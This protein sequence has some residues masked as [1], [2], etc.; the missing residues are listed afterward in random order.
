MAGPT[1]PAIPIS[2]MNFFE[3]QEHARKSS[4]KLVIWF[5][6]CVLGVV[7]LVYTVLAFSAIAGASGS[8]V[9]QNAY[10]PPSFWQPELFLA[11]FVIVG[12]IILIGSLFKLARLSGGGAV[13]ARD[14]GGRPVDPDTRNPLE[15]RLLN[16]V[17]EMAIASGTP[18]PEVWVMDHEDGINAFAAGTDPGNAV[19]GVT[20]GTLEQLT[21]S[22]LQ[23]VIGH[24]YSHILNGDMKLNMRLTG[25][26]FG[27]VM[28]ALVGR[29]LIRSVRFMRGSRNGKGNAVIVG[30]VLLGL[31]VWIIGSIGVLFA[32]MLQA[33][34]SRQREFLADASAVQF[35]RYPDGIAGALKKISSFPDHGK[36]VAAK[37]TEARHMFFASS[38]LSSVLATHPPLEERIRAIEPNWDGKYPECGTDAV[39]DS[40]FKSVG[41]RPTPPPLPVGM[42]SPI[43]IPG[44][45]GALTGMVAAAAM[46]EQEQPQGNSLAQAQAMLFGLLIPIQD[47][48]QGR[49][50]LADQGYDE[51]LINLAIE[52]SNQHSQDSSKEKLTCIDASLPWLRRMTQDQ[53]RTM[54][55]T[56]QLLIEAD[57]QIDL[58]EFMLK[59]V[60]QRHIEIGLGLR[61]P[62]AVHYRRIVELESE[63]ANLLAI[64]SAVSADEDALKPAIAEYREHTSRDLPIVEMDFSEAASG[65]MRM[66]GSTPIVKRQILRLCWLTANQDGEI[67]DSEAEL[68]RAVAEALGCALP[69]SESA[70]ADL[71]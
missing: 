3:A 22:E 65:L 30:I 58:F 28:L 53:G 35:T 71:S 48:D 19:I 9:D 8:S 63:I 67:N 59:Q 32:R 69:R 17:E 66:D 55:S 6:L 31:A 43:G 46:E 23:G 54:I 37:A 40:E 52:A 70:F 64:F 45:G 61:K 21:R 57:G 25:W 15:R 68:L 33:A 49:Q 26:I 12:G 62:P 50:I 41:G 20:R 47:Q 5:S 39:Q 44:M 29:L 51:E 2:S 13:I 24:E 7:V 38:G 10:P 60:S 11:T 27:L 42:G 36:I 4:R 14:L 34:I 1:G 16:V 18:V 56:I